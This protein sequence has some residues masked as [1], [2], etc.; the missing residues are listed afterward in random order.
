MSNGL[1]FDYLMLKK[2]YR[3]K[4]ILNNW[5]KVV[6]SPKLWKY[7]CEINGN[8]YLLEPMYWERIPSSFM[9]EEAT[10]SCHEIEK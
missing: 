4:D 5:W 3:K 8:V 1:Y 7:I 9:C 10:I 6:L 2:I